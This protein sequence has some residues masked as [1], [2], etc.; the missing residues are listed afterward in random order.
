MDRTLRLLMWAMG[1]AC[2]CIGLYHVVGGIATVPGEAHSGATVD[3]RERFYNAIFA[4]YGAAWLYAV[5]RPVVPA[6][7]VRALAAVFLLGGI[8]R[9]L[10]LAVHG[11]P[12]W[13]QLPLIV[14]ELVLPPLFLWLAPAD[15]RARGADRHEAAGR[16]LEPQL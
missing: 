12:H 5:R 4:G 14:L 3:S 16:P 10:S 2:V 1:I 7:W 11:Q 13:F 6:V 8:G 15:E 9:L